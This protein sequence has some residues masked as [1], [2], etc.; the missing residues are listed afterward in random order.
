M[1]SFPNLLVLVVLLLLAAGMDASAQTALTI[2][3]ALT[4][5]RE[6]NPRFGIADKGLAGAESARRELIRQRLPRVSFHGNAT[7]APTF[8]S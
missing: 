5:A 4:I 3:R 7:Y 8:P 6:N 1:R 2:D